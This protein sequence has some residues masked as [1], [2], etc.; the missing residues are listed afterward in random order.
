MNNTKFF[1]NK[2]YVGNLIEYHK[3]DDAWIFILNTCK[4][5]IEINHIESMNEYSN[6]GCPTGFYEVYTKE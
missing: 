5:V 4:V 2:N 6:P 3:S 1:L